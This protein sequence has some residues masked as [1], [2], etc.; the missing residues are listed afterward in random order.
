MSA[1]PQ[2]QPSFVADESICAICQC[3]IGAGDQ[4]TSCPDCHAAYHADCWQDNGGCAVYGC[5]Q[6]PPT[7]KLSDVERTLA[8]PVIFSPPR[9]VGRD[10]NLVPVQTW[11][12]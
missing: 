1:A 8:K 2:S 12:R 6:V 4:R 5:S 11:K 7:Q 10:P 3:P 9:N